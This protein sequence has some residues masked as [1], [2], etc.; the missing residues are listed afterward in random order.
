MDCSIVNLY[1]HK[2]QSQLSHCQGRRQGLPAGP[3][4]HA[5]CT[6]LV[7]AGS[8]WATGYVTAHCHKIV[9]AILDYI[10]FIQ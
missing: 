10:D 9:H 7:A 8:G 2:A 3:G 6:P 1:T 5:E 4:Q